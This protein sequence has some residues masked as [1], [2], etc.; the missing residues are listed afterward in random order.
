[1]NKMAFLG[2]NKEVLKFVGVKAFDYETDNNASINVRL[3][4][5][6][7]YANVPLGYV[8][9]KD[10]D[11]Y[12]TLSIVTDELDS[13]I[14]QLEKENKKLKDTLVQLD[15]A[16]KYIDFLLGVVHIK[17]IYNKEIEEEIIKAEQF[18]K[19]ATK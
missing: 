17:N 8:F 18:L 16:K 11:E 15:K 12:A 5:S 14:E 19:E 7:G 4:G 6:H 1:M 10:N 3:F 2:T 13:Q 9:Y